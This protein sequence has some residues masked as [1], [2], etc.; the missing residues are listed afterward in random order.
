M[1]RLTLTTPTLSV[2]HRIHSAHALIGARGI[3]GAIH[4]SG[5]LRTWCASHVS[6]QGLVL[7]RST[8]TAANKAVRCITAM[9]RLTL[10]AITLSVQHRIHSAHALISARGI[11]DISCNCAALRTWCAS[12]VSCQGLVL[13]GSTRTAANEAVCGV[14]A[15]TRLTLTAITL[16]VQH[17]IHSTHALISARGI[18]NISCN[19]AALR[20][21]CASHVGH[22]VL[23]GRRVT[24]TAT[25]QVICGI[26]TKTSAAFTHMSI[27]IHLRV[28]RTLAAVR[29]CG[30]CHVTR[31]GCP[32]WARV[33]AHISG[34]GLVL[35]GTTR[36]AANRS[37]CCI[38]FVSRITLTT[39]TLSVQHR[40][41]SAQAL[42]SARGIADISCNCAALRT[43]C[44][45]HVGHSVLERR[46]T[47][48]TATNKTVRGIPTIP[49][50]A[51]TTTSLS[52]H[53]CIGAA[54]TGG[55]TRGI[56]VSIC[57][58]RPSRTGRALRVSNIWF[59]CSGAAN[60]A[61]NV[62]IRSIT[63]VSSKTLAD[64]RL[65]IN[66]GTNW[67]CTAVRGC[68][69][70]YTINNTSTHSTRAALR[71]PNVFFVCI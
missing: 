32:E 34:R 56:R 21:W 33:T 70:R 45:S 27:L 62:S 54:Q 15:I 18:A 2:Q 31:N 16:S 42:I 50:R 22:G 14:T 24:W 6:C 9:T 57:N 26:A 20:T 3:H 38:A 52:V 55:R 30:I 60:A 39:P 17:R 69:I 5:T 63:T 11:A 25:N 49:S 19:C 68:G 43:W 47:T 37:A 71:V 44:A 64:V 1:T 13:L 12:H 36:T 4:D 67:T 48:W 41:H 8:R 23:E 59:E 40:I 51:L 7:L 28:E 46:R 29:G 35:S 53:L 65:C 58:A 10:T 66:D 61:S